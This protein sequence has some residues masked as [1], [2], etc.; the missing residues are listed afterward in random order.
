MVPRD[1]EKHLSRRKQSQKEKEFWQSNME[2]AR[3]YLHQNKQLEE[4][5]KE[6]LRYEP[7]LNRVHAILYGNWS[8]KQEIH[9]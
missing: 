4:L 3:I 1:I 7:D 9:R 6:I 2:R 5:E 8:V